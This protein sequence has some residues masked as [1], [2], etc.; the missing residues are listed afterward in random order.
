[1]KRIISLL[2]VLAIFVLFAVG[3]ADMSQIPGKPASNVNWAEDLNKTEVS[4]V[5]S[6][7]TDLGF[8]AKLLKFIADRTEGN[9]MVSPLSFRYAL[10]LLIAGANG[11]TKTEL[12]NALGIESVDEWSEYCKIFNGFVDR[13]DKGLAAEIEEYREMKEKGWI[14][15]NSPEPFRALRVAN[16]I[17]KRNDIEADFEETYKEYIE[18][19]YGAEYRDFTRSN[20]V[21]LINEWAN[22]KTEGMIPKLLPEDYDTSNLAIVLMNALYFKDS[23]VN[24]F[25]KYNT[26]EDDFTTEKGLTVKKDFMYTADYFNYYQDEDTQLVILPMNGGVYMAVVLGDN[27]D[28][29]SKISAAKSE[30]VRLWL[31]KFEIESSFNNREFVDFLKENGVSLAFSSKDAD[32]SSMINHNVYV[33]DIIQKTKIK[34]DE[35]GVEAAAVTAI[36]MNDECAPM[37]PEYQVFKADRPFSF[38]IYTNCNDTAITLF[39]GEYVE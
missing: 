4:K 34:I 26:A 29:A 37:E 36:M 23:W 12:L 21:K 20:A 2:L 27:S 38:Y 8:D 25:E 13:F 39:A 3:C 14:D 35:T 5:D 10:G 33:D 32:F 9:Y 15:S 19:N 24:E 18:K 16:S 6:K 22:T 11:E 31:P 28:I 30:A 1:M 7:L 17:W